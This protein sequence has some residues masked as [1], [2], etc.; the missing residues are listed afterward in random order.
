MTNTRLPSVCGQSLSPLMESVGV[1]FGNR[2]EAEQDVVILV[3]ENVRESTKQQFRD[4]GCILK[5]IKNI[6][7]PYSMHLN[8]TVKIQ[9]GRGTPSQLQESLR[10]HAEQT[11]R[12]EH[13]RV[14]ARDLHGRR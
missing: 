3:S 8:G 12:V 1:H 6:E 13:A 2:N 10:V 9:K 7:N 11:P 14:R 5:E 4:I